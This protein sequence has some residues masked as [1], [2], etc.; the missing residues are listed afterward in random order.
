MKRARDP[1]YLDWIRLQPCVGCGRQPAEP[2]HLKGD[3]S[4]FPNGVGLKSPDHLAMPVCR[5]CHNEHH[6]AAPGWRERQRLMLLKTLIRAI[7]EGVLIRG[8]TGGPF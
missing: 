7:E 8:G 6:A 1:E 2:H 5:E 4:V 3:P